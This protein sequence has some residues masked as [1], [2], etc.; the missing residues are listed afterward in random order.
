[1]SMEP[2]GN[3][4]Q[5]HS[6]IFCLFMIFFPRLTLLFTGICAMPFAGVL[7]WLGWIFLPRITVAILASFFYF[8][9]NPVL[10]VFVWIWALAGESAEKKVVAS[11]GQ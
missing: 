7:F 9:T 4:W 3:F 5:Y 10:C 1:M 11:N 6:I 8:Q 2:A